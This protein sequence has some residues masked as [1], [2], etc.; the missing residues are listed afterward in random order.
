MAASVDSLDEFGAGRKREI[1]AAPKA[2][3][4]RVGQVMDRGRAGRRDVDDARVRQGVLTPKARTALLRGG[5]VAALALAA[6]GVLH[7]VG[8]V[9]DAHS[10]EV[11]APPFRNLLDP[12]QPIATDFGT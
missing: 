4:L 3:A 8:L 10:L 12:G 6:C 2:K 1:L 7:G 9:Q 5:D 11:G